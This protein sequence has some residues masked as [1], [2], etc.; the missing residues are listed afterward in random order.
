MKINL[1]NI[2]SPCEQCFIH[3]YSYS[4]DNDGCQRCEYNI[5]IAILKEVLKENDYCTLCKNVEHIKGV[6]QK[7]GVK[8]EVGD[9]ELIVYFYGVKPSFLFY[10]SCHAFFSGFVHVDKTTRQVKGSLGR[11]VLSANYQKL[12]FLVED[13]G[14]CG[15][16]RVE[17]VG[18]SAVCAFLALDVVDFEV[19]GSANG[20][21]LEF[22]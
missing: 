17:I 4:P 8:V 12:V 15:A 6:D 22:I 19:R 7:A 1:E 5:A 10:F 13:E 16:A 18:E 9:A 14:Y 20:A 21:K 3:A 2:H 11:F